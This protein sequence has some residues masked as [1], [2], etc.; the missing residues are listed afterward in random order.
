MTYKSQ[1]DLRSDSIFT[2][3]WTSAI[4]QQAMVFKDDEDANT[5]ALAEL[6][7]K[8]DFNTINIWTRVICE[9]PGFGDNA[10]QAEISDLAILSAVQNQWATVAALAVTSGP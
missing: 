1:A 4:N 7:L 5:K 10:D 9:T 8:G 6:V 3:R 2:A